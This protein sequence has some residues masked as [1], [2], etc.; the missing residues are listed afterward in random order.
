MKHIQN[1]PA[2]C[3]GKR[4]QKQASE[5]GAPNPKDCPASQSLPLAKEGRTRAASK[6]AAAPL[7]EPSLN[8]GPRALRFQAAGRMQLRIAA[9]AHMFSKVPPPTQ[10]LNIE[11]RAYKMVF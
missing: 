10:I 4:A 2:P 3:L 9:T 6:V 5:N 7:R 1:K 8:P 11:T